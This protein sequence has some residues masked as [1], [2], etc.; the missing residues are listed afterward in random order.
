MFLLPIFSSTM[1]YPNPKTFFFPFFLSTRLPRCFTQAQKPFFSFHFFLIH[2][3]TSSSSSYFLFLLLS[4]TQ[5]PTHPPPPTHTHTQVSLSLSLSLYS[6][7]SIYQKLYQIQKGFFEIRYVRRK[8]KKKRKKK[9]LKESN[10]QI[11]FLFF[12]KVKSKTL[13]SQTK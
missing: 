9:E 2:L 10:K 7:F 3:F 4:S 13:F 5:S 11:H 12:G 1:L 8:K 6:I